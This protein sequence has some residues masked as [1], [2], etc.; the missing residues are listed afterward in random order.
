MPHLAEEC[1]AFRV[2]FQNLPVTL[3]SAAVVP[4]FAQS[5]LSAY[6]YFAVAANNAQLQHPLRV[7]CTLCNEIEAYLRNWLGISLIPLPFLTT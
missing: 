1:E 7:F 5:C 3:K 2:T 6:F 4:F